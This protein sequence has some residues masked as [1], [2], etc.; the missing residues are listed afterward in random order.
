MRYV[1]ALALMV[2]NTC[3]PSDDPVVCTNEAR[4]GVIVKVADASSGLPVGSDSVRVGVTEGT[5]SETRV[6]AP[7][8]AQGGLAMALERSGTYEVRVQATGYEPWTAQNVIVAPDGCH[9]R[10]VTLDVRLRRN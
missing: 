3:G 8:V 1:A 6:V 10:S 2:L 5:Y 7:S 9:V 4:A